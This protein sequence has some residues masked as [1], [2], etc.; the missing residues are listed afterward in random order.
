MNFLQAK[1]INEE[2]KNNKAG[3]LPDNC[4]RQLFINEEKQHV[5]RQQ[6]YL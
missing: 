6:V 5:N 2:I 1:Q 4:F 3:F